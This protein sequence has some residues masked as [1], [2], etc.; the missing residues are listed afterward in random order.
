MRVADAQTD[1][2]RYGWAEIA[3][4]FASLDEELLA[5]SSKQQVVRGRRV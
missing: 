3:A 5:S 4:C 1:S 2:R